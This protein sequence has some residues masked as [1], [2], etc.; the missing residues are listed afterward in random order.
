MVALFVNEQGARVTVDGLRYVVQKNGAT[1]QSV[2]MGDVDSILLFGGVE[3]SG[4]LLRTAARRG[5]NVGLYT[6]DGRPYA[7]L[8]SGTSR[9]VRL[10]ARQFH[11]LTDSASPDPT[12]R[13]RLVRGVVAAKI[14]G[15]RTVLLR[16]QRRRPDD[17]VARAAFRLRRHQENLANPNSYKSAEVDVLRGVEGAAAA[18]YFRVFDRLIVNDA[19]SFP[20]RVRRP[21][22]DPINACLSFGYHIL[23]NVV[24][25]AVHQVGLDP[26]IG[27]LHELQDGRPS[28]V[29]DL[30][31]E[32]RALVVDA[33][34]IKLFN[35]G[36]FTPADFVE[37]GTEVDLP[38]ALAAERRHLG[39]VAS[40]S[41]SNRD[42]K[43]HRE[44]GSTLDDAPQP[45][46]LEATARRILIREIRGRL[47]RRMFDDRRAERRLGFDAVLSQVRQYAEV[48]EDEK[49][50]YEPFRMR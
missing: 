50:S 3:P 38:L 25:S 8:D 21:P 43:S 42:V 48:L 28:L 44:D 31:E 34:V 32:W 47:A 45:V 46:R 13:S 17:A 40:P 10:R 23:Q 24:E 33:A 4:E 2:R 6:R 20:G 15:Q 22:T 5:C 11:Q 12:I 35:R 7:R 19:F 36:Q 37:V 29:L 18:D 1:I 16:A 27:A 30:M 49:T 41:S 26:Q 9:H 14:A 39:S